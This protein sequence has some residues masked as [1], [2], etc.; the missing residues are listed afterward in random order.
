[1][2]DDREV[3][4]RRRQ[5]FDEHLNGVQAGDQNSDAGDSVGAASNGD[6]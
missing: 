2:T 3:I 4:E 6:R 5:H 1:M